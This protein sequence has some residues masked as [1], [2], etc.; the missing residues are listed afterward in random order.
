MRLTLLLRLYGDLNLK[1]LSIICKIIP[2]YRQVKA[3]SYSKCTL[4]DIKENF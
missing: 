3:Y 1:N 4:K 2:F